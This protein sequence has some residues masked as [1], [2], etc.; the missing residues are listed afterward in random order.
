LGYQPDTHS[1]LPLT[2]IDQIK[3]ANYLRINAVNRAGVLA[4]VTH[5]L[6]EHGISI[7]SILQKG[8]G[9]HEDELPVVIVTQETVEANMQ[10]ALEELKAL[11]NVLGDINR[12]RIESIASHY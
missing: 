9:Q 8:S 4:E 10:L 12:I 11:P 3:S 2:S 6:G 1:I 7:E 5:V